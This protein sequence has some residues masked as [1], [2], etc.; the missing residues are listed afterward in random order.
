MF[1]NVKII[2]YKE[3][4]VPGEG[5][6]GGVLPMRSTDRFFSQA[7]SVFFLS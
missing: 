4:G 5:G 2:Y 1:Q 7:L 6:G 3:A